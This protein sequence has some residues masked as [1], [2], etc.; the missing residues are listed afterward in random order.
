MLTSTVALTDGWTVRAVAGPVPSELAGVRVPA[1]VPGCVHTDLLAAGLIPDPYLDENEAALSWI[2]QV[3]W[4]YETSFEHDPGTHVSCLDLVALGLDTVAEVR[5]N[6]VVVGQARN[7]NRTHRFDLRAAVRPGRNHLAVTFAAGLPAAERFSAEL[8]PRPHVNGHPYNGIRKMAANYGWDWGPVLVT[9]GI[10]RPIEVQAW[11]TARL[12]GV[13]PLAT[14]ADG[15]GTVEVHADLARAGSGTLT[16]RVSTADSQVTVPI[17]PDAVTGVARI[18]V[19]DVELWWPHGM[20]AQTRYPLTVELRTGDEVLDRWTGAV[21]FRTV[22]IDMTPDQHGTPF[23]IEVNGVP[24]FARGVNWIPDDC[25][26]SRVSRDRYSAR[27][28]AARDA[29]VTL[30]RVWGGGRYE[31]EDFYDVCDELG[32]L[33]WQD[34][35][36]ACAAYAEEEPL[37][38][39]VEA[40]AREAVT[41]LSAHPSLAVWNGCNENLWGY[42]DWN[43]QDQLADRTWGAGYYYDLLPA[44][45]AELDP[46]RPYAPGSPFSPAGRHP[47]DPSHAT[48]HIWDVWNQLD[49][50]AYRDYTPRFVAEFGFQGPA[51]W[52]TLTRAIHDQ[53]LA[54]DSPG[55]LA[56]QKA[57][58][59]QDKLARGLKAHLPVPANFADWHWA[60]SLN[61]ARAVAFGIEHFRSLRPLCM[62][63]I[64]WQLNDCWPVTSWSAIDGDGRRKP[65]WYAMRRSFADRLVTMQPRGESLALI[66]VN[67]GSSDWHDSVSVRRVAFD[68]TH[69]AEVTI[70]VALAAGTSATYPLPADV[71]VPDDAAR[72]LVVADRAGARAVWM[73]VDDIDAALGYGAFDA[74][75]TRAEDG[76]DVTVQA[77]TLLRDLALLADR[78]DPEA[79]VDEML[80]TLLPGET[81]TLRIRSDVDVDEARWTDPAVLRCANQLVAALP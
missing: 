36:F 62:G 52:S 51:T 44:I 5:V 38:G 42:A 65:M 24:L 19:T 81:I 8:G 29:N 21:G 35:L 64:V 57:E 12:A 55:V 67:D 10:W 22:R 69:R 39:E 34:F 73:F 2:G 18:E 11:H 58:S 23:V 6:D 20:G 68:G 14:V 31:S 59:G 7:M 46:T 17:G 61:Q 16:L 56:H 66:A 37:R 30:V 70:D 78:V 33:V 9:A 75:V 49:Y 45:L 74:S 63:T 15:I 43:W 28:H 26:P 54:T 53:P 80:V 50:T 72:E 79:E 71:A 40:E 13:R 1:T 76:Y 25:F 60:T 3:D 32:L 41:R 47:N 4:C 48:M 77:R 27:L